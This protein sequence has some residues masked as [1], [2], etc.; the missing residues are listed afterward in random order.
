MALVVYEGFNVLHGLLMD[1]F[2]DNVCVLG[3]GGLVDQ[4]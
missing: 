3:G 1:I 2:Q 4:E